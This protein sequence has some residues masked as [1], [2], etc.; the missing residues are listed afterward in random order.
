MK[1]LINFLILN[2]VLISFAS[3]NEFNENSLYADKVDRAYNQVDLPILPGKWKIYD[4]EKSGSV[5]S[6]NFYV[7]ATLVPENFGPNDN[8]FYVDSINYA[9]LGSNSEETDYRKT[10][11][12]CD[13][14]IYTA[15]PTN[16]YNINYRGLG[17]FEETCSAFSELTQ[18]STNTI[19]QF[20]LTDCNDICVEVNF[21]LF[22][23]S[24]N[25]TENNF[26]EFSNLLFNSI[27]ATIAGDTN[28]NEFAFLKSYR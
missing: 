5:P 3:A 1:N 7:Y 11:Y 13:A 15:S 23:D 19:H 17:N 26:D 14:G 10:F 9:I 24:Y 6:G 12:G 21:A 4:L 8:A 20:Y 28:E 25:L 2:L 27:R 16:T 22:K 18:G